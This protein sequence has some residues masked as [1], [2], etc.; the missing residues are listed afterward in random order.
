MTVRPLS[1]V[2]RK[3]FHANNFAQLNEP[4]GNVGQLFVATRYAQQTSAHPAT[5]NAGTADHQIFP[6]HL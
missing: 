6:Y 2:N 5:S 3:S 1:G 4:L